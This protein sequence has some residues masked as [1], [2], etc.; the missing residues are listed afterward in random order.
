MRVGA[1]RP[2]HTSQG[3]DKN[4]EGTEGNNADEDAAATAQGENKTAE[5]DNEQ[6]SGLVCLLIS[7][8]IAVFLVSEML[9][10]VQLVN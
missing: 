3:E 6:A 8:E 7:I 4:N 5:N 2:R 10:I 9:L 1:P